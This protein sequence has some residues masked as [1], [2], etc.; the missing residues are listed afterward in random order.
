MKQREQHHEGQEDRHPADSLQKR[1]KDLIEY[2]RRYLQLTFGELRVASAREAESLRAPLLAIRLDEEEIRGW[3]R[4]RDEFAPKAIHA[5]EALVA[6]YESLLDHAEG[7]CLLDHESAERWRRFFRSS[8]VDFREKREAL[9]ELREALS[10]ERAAAEERQRVLDA[11]GKREVT[12][13]RA[14]EEQGKPEAKN[15]KQKEHAKERLPAEQESTRRNQPEQEDPAK[16]GRDDE[17][18]MEATLRAL[19]GSLIPL[20]ATAV[21]RGAEAV[22]ALTQVMARRMR[23]EERPDA[24]RGS[25]ADRRFVVLR[26]EESMEAPERTLEHVKCMAQLGDEQPV[27]VPQGVSREAQAEIVRHVH[28]VLQSRDAGG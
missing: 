4:F 8:A 19:P 24:Q 17:A 25:G 20:Y 18:E 9:A 6:A 21:A 15:E 3:E 27:M 1:R 28:P 10:A 22:R 16:D 14:R 23:H 2:F 12:A 5:A 13:R 11:L 7:D 26:R